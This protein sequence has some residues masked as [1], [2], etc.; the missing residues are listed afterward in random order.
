M[1]RQSLTKPISLGIL[2]LTFIESPK[3]MFLRPSLTSYTQ[4]LL[5]LCMT[6]LPL[7]L[8][9]LSQLTLS[10]RIF[11]QYLATLDAVNIRTSRIRGL[12]EPRHDIGGR[13]CCMTGSVLLRISVSVHVDACEFFVWINR[14]MGHRYNSGSSMYSIGCYCHFRN[15]HQLDSLSTSSVPDSAD[16]SSIFPSTASFSL[17]DTILSSVVSA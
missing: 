16:S 13:K 14:W 8:Q 17:P 15:T 12:G 7:L 5:F 9:L 10:Y 1:S 3:A 2:Y 11:E 4:F 6:S